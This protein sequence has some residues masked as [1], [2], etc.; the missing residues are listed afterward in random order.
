MSE[1]KLDNRKEMKLE[2]LFD[3]R[4]GV[5]VKRIIKKDNDEGCTMRVL[6]APD[7]IIEETIKS[8]CAY[9][10]IKDHK[11]L[12]KGDF[13]IS[14]V[15]PHQVI[16][17][18]DKYAGCITNQFHAVLRPKNKYAFDHNYLDLVLYKLSTN[19]DFANCKNQ[20]APKFAIISLKNL[21][22]LPVSVLDVEKQREIGEA[23]IETQKRIRLLQELIA[24]EE[25]IIDEEKK[26]IVWL[27]T[28]SENGNDKA[29]HNIRELFTSQNEW[30]N[31]WKETSKEMHKEIHNHWH[32][33]LNDV[34]NSR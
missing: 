31:K 28:E 26:A 15:Y 32:S 22:A 13:V 4:S 20:G 9:Q 7:K 3:I 10:L 19:D 5:M 14:L 34:E 27:L 17:V 2:D 6:S 30:I 18:T 25:K 29:P 1:N 11:D 12:E 24:I 21:K 8:S 23:F 16:K 33:I